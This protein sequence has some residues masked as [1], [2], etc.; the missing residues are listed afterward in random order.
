MDFIKKIFI[1]ILLL[2]PLGEIIR[3]DLGNGLFIKPIDILVVVFAIF[4]LAF[5]YFKKQNVK[6]QKIL[7]PVL[8]FSLTGFLSLLIHNI[9]LSLIEF[10]NSSLYLL[11]WMAYASLFFAVLDFN[12]EFRKKISKLLVVAGGAIVGL[13]YIQYFFYSD[14]HNLT[15]LGWDEHMYRMFSVFL[16][17]NFAGAFFV[18]FFLFLSKL[19]LKR[20]SVPI[21]I[22]TILTLIATFLTFSRSALIA[23]I[24]GSSVLFVM[25]NRKHL[26]LLLFLTIAIFFSISSRYFNIENLNLF[27]VISSEARVETSRNALIVIRDNP[28]FGVGFNAYKYYQYKYGF[29]DKKN[30][31]SHADASPDNSFLFVLVTTGIVGFAFYLLLWF[32]ILRFASPLIM[33]SAVSIFADSMFINSLFY[34]FVMMWL[35]IIIGLRENK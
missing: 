29:R 13:G 20:V 19:F 33:A 8:L 24:L 10:I 14:L 18:L 1:C 2:F 34:P 27:R 17:P 30:V 11:R 28:V 5:K 6:N 12:S 35:W 9:Q 4:W 22:L 3:F 25:E 31:K 16:D 15:Y 26:V 7:G 21:G 23:L 32:R